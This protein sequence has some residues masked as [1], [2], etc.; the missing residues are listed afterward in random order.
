M[1]A[2][3][4]S[5]PGVPV[6]GALGPMQAGGAGRQLGPY[7]RRKL[8]LTLPNER[9]GAQLQ[10]LNIIRRAMGLPP[11]G[12][13]VGDSLVG[14]GAGPGGNPAGQLSY[15]AAAQ[16][17][18]L[19]SDSQGAGPGGNP[20]G[21]PDAQAQWRSILQTNL[22]GVRPDTAPYPG[23]VGHEQPHTGLN[24]AVLGET[25]G[26]RQ[27]QQQTLGVEQVDPGFDHG[28]VDP[29]DLILRRMARLAPVQASTSRAG[30]QQHVA[31]LMQQQGRKTI[32][33]GR[34]PLL[35]A[36]RHLPY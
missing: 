5:A 2:V 7:W 24:Q 36:G 9:T 27:I 14:E 4:D 32:L 11:A 28:P 13:K 26:Q 23:A 34:K 3:T 29:R 15:P 18:A 20:A 22:A 6:A 25:L 19:V 30:L 33:P 31:R 1:A 21:Q 8:G 12:G 10:R 17:H 35:T 16:A